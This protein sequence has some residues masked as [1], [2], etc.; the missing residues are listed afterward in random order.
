[1]NLFKRLF[2][3]LTTLTALA[4][5]ESWNNTFFAQLG[6]GL[7]VSKGDFNDRVLVVK[8]EDG[9]KGNLHPATLKFLGS[10]D[11]VLGLNLNEFSIALDFQY[12]NSEQSLTG[13]PNGAYKTDTQIWRFGSEFTYNLYWPEFFQIGLGAGISLNRVSVE[14][15]L[16]FGEKTYDVDFTGVSLGLLANLHYYITDSFAMVPSL[17]IYETMFWD[18]KSSPIDG[19]QLKSSLW[20][21]FILVSLNVQYQF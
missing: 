15:N 14:D 21:T 8:D 13:Y 10:P 12:W 16:Y 5:A 19:D 1:M 17:K 9:A 6:F 11:F 4:S 2:V 18:M 20:H 3:F 7:M